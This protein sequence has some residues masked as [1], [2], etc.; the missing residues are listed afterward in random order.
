MKK[1]IIFI[2]LFSLLLTVDL[3]SQ[4]NC[5]NFES[6]QVSTG[7]SSLGNGNW[8][9]FNDNA[10]TISSPPNILIR[11]DNG[12]KVISASD[13]QGA[14]Y[15]INT[16]DFDG[17]W[18]ANGNSCFCLDIKLIDDG[19]NPPPLQVSHGIN[20]FQ[21]LNLSAPFSAQ[22]PFIRFVFT[23]SPTYNETS[24]WR[25]ICL[26][27]RPIGPN[28]PLPSNSDGQWTASNNL[29]NFN[30]SQVWQAWNTIISNVTEVGFFV[31]ATSA[32]Q[33]EVIGLD[34]ICIG[35]E[36][37]VC[38]PKLENLI[39]NFDFNNSRP[40]VGFNSQYTYDTGLPSLGSLLPGEYEI[41][42]PQGAAAIC[43]NWPPVKD[44]STCPT[45]GTG[46][47]MIVNGNTG[48]IS[49]LKKLVWEQIINNVQGGKEYKFCAHFKNLPQCCF[50]V[51][52]KID[53]KFVGV[54]GSDLLNQTINVTSSANCGWLEL[55]K[56]FSVVNN[57]ALTIQIWLDESSLGDGNDLAIDDISFTALPPISSNFT[58]F[59]ISL[60]ISQ[61]GSLYSLTFGA[62]PLPQGCSCFWEV[63]ELDPATDQCKVNPNTTVS[64]NA[65][66]WPLPNYCS[67]FN[68]A[69]YNGTSNL[70]PFNSLGIPA[71]I[72]D[73]NKS[74]RIT[75]GA[76]CECQGWGSTSYDLFEKNKMFI[77]RDSKTKVVIQKIPVPKK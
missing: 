65:L 6:F 53:I 73:I 35:C 34:N 71:G 31:D 63:C 59:S 66:W 39:S 43:P 20:I 10:G 44:H 2:W 61:G 25:R 57:T 1:N 9:M 62:N 54:S 42:N 38:C 64:N 40:P 26:P 4:K 19:N 18:T 48:Q 52:P 24:P 15:L 14:T 69:G 22:N 33:N 58:A 55:S 32:N 7:G 49:P 28:D 46:D 50:D 70:S 76:W 47:F 67:S 11:S 17:D 3:Y 16:Q 13:A 68:F 21:N 72:F 5:Q 75:R 56:N 8:V 60:P 29:G 30:A 12:G 51:I 74:Y 41:T 23:V 77:L 37:N 27:I 36:P 45:N